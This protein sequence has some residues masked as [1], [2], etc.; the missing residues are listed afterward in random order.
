MWNPLSVYLSR[1]LN[2]LTSYVPT[3]PSDSNDPKRKV[4]VIHCH[5][6]KDSL[7]TALSLAAVRGLNGAGHEVRLK[8]LYC[9]D[10][11]SECYAGSTFE[12]LLTDGERREYF[13]EEYTKLRKNNDTLDQVPNLTQQVKEAIKDLRWCDSIVFVYPTWFFSL[14]AM[15][16]GTFKIHL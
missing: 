15:L 3:P 1:K 6:V 8:R 2:T 5:P 4:L 16:K 10:D 14:P 9:L 12:P 11:P 7:S 13:N